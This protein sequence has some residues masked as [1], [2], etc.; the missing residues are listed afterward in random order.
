MN[1]RILLAVMA[2]IPFLPLPATAKANPPAVV[3]CDRLGCSDRPA[4]R[5]EDGTHSVRMPRTGR[6]SAGAKRTHVRPAKREVAG[7]GVVRSHKTGAAAHVA[8]RWRD[9]FQA[10]VDDIEAAGATVYF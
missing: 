4:L 2:A 9:A 6:H 7:A 10:Y 1:P 8:P 5:N 3:S